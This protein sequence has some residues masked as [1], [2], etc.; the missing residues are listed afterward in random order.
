MSFLS[1]TPNWKRCVE[2]SKTSFSASIAYTDFIVKRHNFVTYAR[3]DML[4]NGPNGNGCDTAVQNHI[5]HEGMPVESL[6]NPITSRLQ[7]NCFRPVTIPTL[8]FTGLLPDAPSS[9][10]NFC[11][12]VGFFRTAKWLILWDERQ[13]LWRWISVRWVRMN[14]KLVSDARIR[15]IALVWLGMHQSNDVKACRQPSKQFR[16]SRNSWE[17]C[18]MFGACASIWCDSCRMCQC[19]IH[20]HRSWNIY[21]LAWP[22]PWK[23]I[24]S[25]TAPRKSI[26]ETK[27]HPFTCTLR[28]DD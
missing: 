10:I 22:L 21:R 28:Y 11:N 19:S 14:D 24:H 13:S 1:V 3:C 5:V 23:W 8:I 27:L 26:D 4:C 25:A 7:S 18:K 6:R 20:G 9:A 17:A 2:D 16:S 12:G 15:Y